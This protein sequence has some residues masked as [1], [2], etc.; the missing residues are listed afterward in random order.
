MNTL[1]FPTCQKN[2]PGY[3]MQNLNLKSWIVIKKLLQRK[4][5]FLLSKGTS[6]F[7]QAKIKVAEI[8]HNFTSTKPFY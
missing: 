2:C 5:S 8:V 3:Q 6:I 4:V 7:S 1:P